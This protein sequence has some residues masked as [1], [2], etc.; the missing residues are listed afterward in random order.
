MMGRLGYASLLMVQLLG[1]AFSAALILITFQNRDELQAAVQSFA[2]DKVETATTEFLKDHAD[3]LPTNRLAALADRLGADAAALRQQQKR[4]V[5]ALLQYS[6]SDRCVSDCGTAAF[7]ALA[8]DIT[9]TERVAQTRVGETTVRD[10]IVGSYDKTVNGLIADLRR[11]GIVN[12]VA[13]VLMIGLVLFRGMRDWRFATFSI[14]LTV[15]AGWAIHGYLFRQDWVR[16]VLF[17][18]W[19]APGYQLAMVVVSLVLADWL[20][21]RGFVTGFIGNA[22]STVLPT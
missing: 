15:Y 9:L 22:I 14:A 5:D 6:L 21:L 16:T 2:I 19:A 8:T 20:F 3:T 11:F 4:M 13:F 1:F 12:A 7:A 18:D 10:F 17:N